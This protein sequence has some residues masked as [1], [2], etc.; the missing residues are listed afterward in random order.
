MDLFYAILTLCVV[1]S[2]SSSLLIYPFAFLLSFASAVSLLERRV[3]RRY[4][5]ASSLLL[6]ATIYPVQTHYVISRCSSR[7]VM[8]SRLRSGPTFTSVGCNFLLCGSYAG[9]QN[10]TSIFSSDALEIET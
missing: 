1:D 3:K 7:Y 5:L 10:Q 6:C 4:P 8:L 9:K 2:H